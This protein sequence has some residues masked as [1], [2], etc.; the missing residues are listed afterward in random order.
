MSATNLLDSDVLLRQRCDELANIS[1]SD[2]REIHKTLE[3]L[4]RIAGTDMIRVAI[5]ADDRPRLEEIAAFFKERGGL[6]FRKRMRLALARGRGPMSVASVLVRY[7][8]HVTA[9]YKRMRRSGWRRRSLQE[10]VGLY[11]GSIAEC[12]AGRGHRS[13]G[14]RTDSS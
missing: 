14:P 5:E 9:G 6:S 4:I 13:A 7:L 11:S 12:S 8:T 1:E 2:R 3:R 10:I